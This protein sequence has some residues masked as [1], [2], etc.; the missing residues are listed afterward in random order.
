VDG[1]LV[2]IGGEPVSLGT[3]G[4]PGAQ[5]RAMGYGTGHRSDLSTAVSVYCS[6]TTGGRV[7]PAKRGGFGAIMPG[8]RAS[9]CPVVARDLT[10]L[11]YGVLFLLAVAVVLGLLLGIDRKRHEEA[12]HRANS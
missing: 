12:G 2:T 7:R 5:G 6:L 4:A 9:V 10:G 11:T 3:S 1:T 8:P